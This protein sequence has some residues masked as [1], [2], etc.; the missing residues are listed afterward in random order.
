MS[1]KGP[2]D[3]AIQIATI[4]DDLNIAYALGGSLAS[5]LVGE[6]RSTIDVDMAAQLESST[7]EI[8]LEK[9]PNEI[10]VPLDSVKSAVKFNSS[11]NLIDIENSLKI[12]IFVCSDDTLDTQQIKRRVL[13]DLPGRD[14]KL[15]VTSPEDQVLRKLNWYLLNN[16]AL[17]K[18]IS[19]V[20]G[21]LKINKNTID[22]KYMIEQSKTLGLFKLL[23]Q[24]LEQSD[25]IV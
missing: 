23:M 18:Q 14:Y 2:L 12:D 24:V 17:G 15:W 20:I 16:K 1:N 5:S 25:I 8:F 22:I 21:V 11:F 7:I 9:L 13:I 4:L 19:D 6:P 3:L 10:Y